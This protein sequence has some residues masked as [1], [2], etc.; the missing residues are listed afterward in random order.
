[1]EHAQRNVNRSHLR[2]QARGAGNVIPLFSRCLDPKGLIDDEWVNVERGVQV[3]E[4]LEAAGEHVPMDRHQDSMTELFCRPYS[5]VAVYLRAL[6][7]CFFKVFQCT[8]SS[9]VKNFDGVRIAGGIGN[10]VARGE[11]AGYLSVVCPGYPVL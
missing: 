7:A 11:R 8:S 9:T 10:P 6:G 2:Y 3:E 4:F 1:M 5:D